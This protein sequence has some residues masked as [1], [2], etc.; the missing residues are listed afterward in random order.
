MKKLKIK[1]V[2]KKELE[3]DGFD[4][5]PVPREKKRLI[6]VKR[7]RKQDLDRFDDEF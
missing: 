6:P 7:I 3:D 2:S 1:N 4:Y 5:A